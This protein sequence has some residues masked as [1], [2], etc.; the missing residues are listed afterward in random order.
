[1]YSFMYSFIYISIVI[2][3]GVNRVFRSKPRGPCFHIYVYLS[4]SI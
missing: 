4:I 3:A 2:S 1:M